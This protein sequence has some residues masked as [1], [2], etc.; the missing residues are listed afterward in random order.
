MRKHILLSAFLPLL[1]LAQSPAQAAENGQAKRTISMVGSGKVNAAPDIAM[2]GLGVTSRGET[3]REALN[4]NTKAMSALLTALKSGG[5]AEKDIQTSN[6]SI[7]PVYDHPRQQNPQKPKLPRIVGYNVSNQVSAMVRNP[8]S[9]G[10]LLDKSV[11][12]GS[13][14]INSVQFSIDKQKPLR[15]VARKLAVEDAVRKAKLYADAAGVGLGDIINIS[16]AGGVRPPRPMMM[17]R[18]EMAADSAPVPIARG[19]Q[20]LSVNVN[21]TWEIK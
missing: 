9:L 6:F 13:N 16:E 3:A 4:E 2:I 10:A 8:D 18:A 1:L 14:Q 12:V 7:Q 5:I 11:S 19:E 15:D 21:I 17:R 20:T